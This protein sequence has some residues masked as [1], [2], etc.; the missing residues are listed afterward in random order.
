MAAWTVLIGVLLLIPILCACLSA[1]LLARD[2]QHTR[3]IIAAANAPTVPISATATSLVTATVIG[4]TPGPVNPLNSPLT[5]VTAEP[6]TIAES[7]SGT[8]TLGDLP[9]PVTLEV[10]T[11]QVADTATA[12]PPAFLT[13]LPTQA[14]QIHATPTFP[15]TFTPL[16]VTFPTLTPAI[17]TST[18]TP[19]VTA[20]HTPTPEHTSTVTAT[21]TSTP[22]PTYGPGISS[23][24]V[25]S[26]V[27]YRGNTALNMSDQF[28][29]IQNR[30]TIEVN[31]SGWQIR[32][33]SS[34]K[35]FNFPSGLLL[36][37]GETCRIYGNS[38]PTTPESCGPYSFN[39]P[40]Q[41]WST[42]HDTAQLHD[43]NGVLVGV[44]SY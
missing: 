34:G 28:V 43:G 18:A 27:M 41:V 31:I 2:I 38:P 32:A 19:Q 22:T 33:L 5:T 8:V 30:G 24:V 4:S 7:L 26:T 3:L 25:I 23:T 35:A 12:T 11:G 14:P 1:I 42:T 44:Y 40:D 20:T 9:T 15:P 17:E 10:A 6:T 37:A 36:L 29:E 39:S 21:V 16:P 13:P